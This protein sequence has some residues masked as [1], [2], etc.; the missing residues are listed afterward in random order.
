MP[1]TK[2]TSSHLGFSEL[3]ADDDI[4]DALIN[5]PPDVRWRWVRAL[6]RIEDPRRLAEIR[7]RFQ[8]QVEKIK[9]PPH[10]KVIFRLQFAMQSIQRPVHVKAYAVVKGKGAFTTDELAADE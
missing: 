9:T 5:D 2:P 3:P 4:I 1:Q 6:L 8:E 7:H 10:W